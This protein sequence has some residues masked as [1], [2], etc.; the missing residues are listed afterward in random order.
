M[1]IAMNVV[2][3]VW[4]IAALTIA[5]LA[6]ANAAHSA[7]TASS[8]PPAGRG[9]MAPNLSTV[10]GDVA[11]TWLERVDTSQASQPDRR[12]RL[13]ALRFARYVKGGWSEPKTIVTRDDFFANWADLPALVQ[14]EDGTLF[15]HWLQ[16]SADATYA[17][18]VVVARSTD[19]GDSWRTLGKLHDDQAQAEHGFV[20]FVAQSSSVRAFWLDGREMG[21]GGHGE[22]LD[23]ADAGSMTLRTA[24]VGQKISPSTLI[25]KRVCECCNT[26]AAMTD[27]GEIVVYRD[28]GADE[29]RDIYMVR[30][31]GDTWTDPTLLFA[32]SWKIAGCPVNGPAIA[33]DGS[34]VVV[35][36]F[37][38]ATDTGSV[39]AVFS[40]NGGAMFGEP[41]A[42][43]DTWP[44][45]RVGVVL[46]KTGE[47]IVSWL[48]GGEGG[49]AIAIRRVRADGA[50]GVPLIVAKTNTAR[51]VG[52]PKLAQ[53]GSDLLL[54]WT[55]DSQPTQLRA[56][57]TPITEIPAATND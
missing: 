39:R 17:Y 47:A 21:G 27:R 51:A 13:R 43:D 54:V 34:N 24:I 10:D 56:V 52:F 16:K 53:V 32:D 6:F 33:A 23:D 9:A 40:T 14:A 8:D 19:G 29:T 20:S 12:S 36:W 22:E 11:L 31:L 55:E 46:V 42:V 41:I 45:G 35:A 7:Q 49:G 1:V 48:D 28:R 26:S 18:D 25:D 3:Y 37:T 44:M 38:G 57:T 30:H 15:A 4:M 50:R 5:P 2:R